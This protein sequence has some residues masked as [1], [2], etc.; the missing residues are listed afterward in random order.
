MEPLVIWEEMSE[1]HLM[2]MDKD[3]VPKCKEYCYV[4]LGFV[5]CVL[6]VWNCYIFDSSAETDVVRRFRT[7]TKV[8]VYLSQN[9]NPR[10]SA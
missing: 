5:S 2:G 6:N 8:F 1:Q 10:P 3:S 9:S 7:S 4:V